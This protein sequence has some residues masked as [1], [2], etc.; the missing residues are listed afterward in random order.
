MNTIQSNSSRSKD[1]CRLRDFILL[2][3]LSERVDQLT[4]IQGISWVAGLSSEFPALSNSLGQCPFYLCSS[5]PKLVASGRRIGFLAL[6]YSINS[7]ELSV[8]LL[9][10]AIYRQGFYFLPEQMI[11]KRSKDRTSTTI[12]CRENTIDLEIIIMNT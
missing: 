9:I 6:H 5:H 8:F 1:Q 2:P 3:L 7:S 11:A 10:N 12:Y 4:L